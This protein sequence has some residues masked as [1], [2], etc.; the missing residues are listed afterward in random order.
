MHL[1]MHVPHAC[2]GACNICVHVRVHMCVRVCLRAGV[3]LPMLDRC[4]GGLARHTSELCVPP[5]LLEDYFL[6]LGNY[7]ADT[8]A[9]RGA[10]A[11]HNNNACVR[12]VIVIVLI[13]LS[14]VM[15]V[16]VIAPVA[17]ASTAAAA[18]GSAIGGTS[19]SDRGFG[20]ART[21]SLP[22]VAQY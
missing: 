15:A 5:S 17:A 7:I 22:T 11:H 16:I 12:T 13:F 14:I 1:R 10:N 20:R 21:A 3:W 19:S 8:F 18:V 9:D 4:C 6:F 2:V